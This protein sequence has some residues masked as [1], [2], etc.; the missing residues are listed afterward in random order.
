MRRPTRLFEI[1]QILRAAEYP[2]TADQIAE[3]LEVS[4][5]TIYRDIAVLQSMRTPI[6][7]EAGIGYVMRVGY[8]LP[9]L[10]FDVE[11]IEALYVGLSLLA[12]TGDA[13]LKKAAARISQ[14]I[15][16]L[17]ADMSGIMV[18]DWG[19]KEPPVVSASDLRDTIRAEQKLA[20]VYTD[21]EGKKT[22]RVILPIGITY[23]V[24]VVTLLA[25]CELRKDFRNFRLDRIV[26]CAFL[27]DY[28]L[29]RGEGLRVQWEAAQ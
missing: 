29:G 28:F 12:R 16:A 3:T 20:F 17:G 18:S 7:G 6:E 1:I 26:S 14:K 23:Y 19:A 4:T 2:M 24:E 27:E 11:E 15:D 22:E 21:A 25:W 13:G 5:R 8:D 9:P 10:N